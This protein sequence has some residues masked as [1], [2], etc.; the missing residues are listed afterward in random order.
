MSLLQDTKIDNYLLAF[1]GPLLIVGV[2]DKDK[3]TNIAILITGLIIYMFTIIILFIH[4]KDYVVFLLVCIFIR[5]SIEL[6]K[7]LVN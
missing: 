6:H 5:D 3:K 1:I 7:L 4:Q 2:I